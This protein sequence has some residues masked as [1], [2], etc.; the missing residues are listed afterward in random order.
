M[1]DDRRE[2]IQRA[3]EKAGHLSPSEI[4]QFEE[5]IKAIWKYGAG[6]TE[7]LYMTVATIEPE[8]AKSFTEILQ[9]LT[10]S[11]SA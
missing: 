7:A 5:L 4:K 9:E 6:D 10:G 11:K 3:L 1:N 2:R 8:V